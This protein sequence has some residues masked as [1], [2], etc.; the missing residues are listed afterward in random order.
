MKDHCKLRAIG[1]LSRLR[2]A[3]STRTTVTRLPEGVSHGWQKQYACASRRHAK[4]GGGGEF[5]CCFE[6][7]LVEAAAIRRVRGITNVLVSS[8]IQTHRPSASEGADINVCLAP[9]YMLNHF[10]G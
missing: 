7:W 10:N 6:V 5:F 9:Q 3:S 1:S 4:R 2:A 8:L